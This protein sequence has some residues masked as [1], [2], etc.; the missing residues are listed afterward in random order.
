MEG[1]PSYVPTSLSKYLREEGTREGMLICPLPLMERAF[2]TGVSRNSLLNAL[3]S[4]FSKA[5]SPKILRH[6]FD[7]LSGKLTSE[8]GFIKETQTCIFIWRKFGQIG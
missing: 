1:L 7:A 6:G 2:P 3:N 5:R 8:A 4:S